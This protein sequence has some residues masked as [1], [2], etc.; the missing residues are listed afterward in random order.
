MVGL[1]SPTDAAQHQRVTFL[2]GFIPMLCL[3]LFFLWPKSPQ[4]LVLISAMMQAIML[5]MLSAAALYF[6]YYKCDKRVAPGIAWDI[7]LILSSLG[8]LITAGCLIYKEISKF[9]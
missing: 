7:F 2:S 6:R 3:G 5:P 8:M 1:G 9:L 4:N